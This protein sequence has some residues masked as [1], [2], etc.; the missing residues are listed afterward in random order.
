MRFELIF[1]QQDSSEQR[2]VE[3]M[4]HGNKGKYALHR[5]QLHIL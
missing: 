3:N 2:A 4:M 5:E 1:V